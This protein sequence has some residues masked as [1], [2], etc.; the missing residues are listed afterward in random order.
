MPIDGLAFSSFNLYRNLTPEEITLQAEKVSKVQ[1]ETPIKQINKSNTK[2]EINSEN[3]NDKNREDLQGR[4]TSDDDDNK[5]ESEELLKNP[6]NIQEYKMNFNK[7]TNSVELID[8]KTG[9][10]MKILSQNELVSLSRNKNSSGILVDR[11]A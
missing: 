4:D 11:E 3:K 7:S 10:I 9:V 8:K 5:N 6:E 2:S 1:A